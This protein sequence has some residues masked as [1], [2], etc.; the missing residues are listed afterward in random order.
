MA[1]QPTSP[2][3]L[4][5]LKEHLMVWQPMTHKID[6]LTENHGTT[7]RPKL[8][9]TGFV[10]HTKPSGDTYIEPLSEFWRSGLRELEFTHIEVAAP[11]STV[12]TANAGEG[13]LTRQSVSSRFGGRKP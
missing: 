8:K 4:R 12:R 5:T 7:K 1:W 11:A 13:S 3:W 2:L 6:L 10:R 9:L